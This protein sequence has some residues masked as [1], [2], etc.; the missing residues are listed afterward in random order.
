MRSWSCYAPFVEVQG[1]EGLE[2]M[3]R[4]LRRELLAALRVPD[5]R[6]PVKS[7]WPLTMILAKRPEPLAARG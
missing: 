6:T 5:K 2:G 1:E 7:V 4:M 3:M